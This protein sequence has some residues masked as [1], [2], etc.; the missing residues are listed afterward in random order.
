MAMAEDWIT[1]AACGLDFPPA[2]RAKESAGLCSDPGCLY[3][4]SKPAVRAR[5]QALGY[6][7][8]NTGGGCTAWTHALPGGGYVLVTNELDAFGDPD[9]AEWDFGLYDAAG[10]AC[11]PDELA[12]H[13]RLTLAQA[14]ARG[15]E[16]IAEARF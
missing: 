14:I 3:E 5:M 2:D 1:C 10:E 16:A 15:A 6:A 11:N 9:A 7:I 8:E 12:Q 13:G 4:R